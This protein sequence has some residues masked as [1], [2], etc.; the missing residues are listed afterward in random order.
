M[1]DRPDKDALLDALAAFL[2]RELLPAVTD[3]ALAFRVR[4]AAHLLQGLA[5]EVRH[6]EEFD[7]VHLATLL[8]LLGGGQVPS[9]PAARRDAIRRAEAD[10]AELV[11]GAD[12]NDAQQRPMRAAMRRILAD[13]ARIGDPRF[14]PSDDVE[15]PR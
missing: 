4:I 12:L 14:D 6:E 7:Q 3:R 15:E 11:R 1:L 2:A 10:L 5:R 9:S 13:K 8:E